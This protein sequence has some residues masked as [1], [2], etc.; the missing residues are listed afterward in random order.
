MVV[1]VWQFR[2]VHVATARL[3]PHGAP[4]LLT[5]FGWSQG[6]QTQMPVWDRQFQMGDREEDSREW[7]GLWQGEEC[8]FFL[9]RAVLLQLKLIISQAGL[10]PETWILATLLRPHLAHG[11]TVRDLCFLC[12]LLL[13]GCL[14]GYALSEMK[15]NGPSDW[16]QMAP[17]P[18]CI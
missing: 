9:K 12:F 8:M 5:F 15:S 4:L 11:P 1:C 18:F 7:W 3:M 16:N 17:T 13:A 6:L 10:L 2:A 14:R